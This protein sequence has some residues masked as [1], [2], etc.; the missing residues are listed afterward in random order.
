MYTGF[1]AGEMVL[2]EFK[3][4]C[5][6]FLN[7]PASAAAEKD[8][9]D[10]AIR[11][12]EGDLKAK[13]GTGEAGGEALAALFKP[14]DKH[15]RGE[16]TLSDMRTALERCLGSPL[17][18]VVFKA[19]CNKYDSDDVGAFLYLEWA[20]AFSGGEFRPKIAEEEARVW[21]DV[22]ALHDFGVRPIINLV[23][24]KP[25][26]AEELVKKVAPMVGMPECEVRMCLW[27]LGRKSDLTARLVEQD[28]RQDGFLRDSEIRDVLERMGLIVGDDLMAQITSRCEKNA[29]GKLSYHDMIRRIS[30]FIN[31]SAGMLEKM[32]LE[33]DPSVMKSRERMSKASMH[34]APA[35][36]STP[37]AAPSPAQQEQAGSSAKRGFIAAAAA[38]YDDADR[39]SVATAALDLAPVM[40]RMRRVLGASWPTVL[41]D[42]SKSG[43]GDTVVSGSI[44]RDSLASKGIALTSKEVRALSLRYHGA[45]PAVTRDGDNSGVVDVAALFKEAFAAK[46]APTA[47]AVSPSKAG[48]ASRTA[49]A[50]LKSPLAAT[51]SMSRTGGAS[52]PGSS[53][54]LSSTTMAIKKISHPGQA[55]SLF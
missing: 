20:E 29:D 24:R 1:F 39:H 14:Y 25:Y 15:G 18:P 33:K 32:M 40:Q 27:M 21:V 47:G 54:K 30:P 28:V 3:E 10:D 38:T 53:Q 44:L 42:V 45:G 8:E 31:P 4:C 16:V 46:A 48:A 51:A 36:P 50:S 35:S 17:R 41:T 55:K 12:V 5:A 23:T 9:K 22:P 49:G 34:E 37:K 26:T 7:M 52:S 6:F 43:K 11:V 19:L 13:L 2:D